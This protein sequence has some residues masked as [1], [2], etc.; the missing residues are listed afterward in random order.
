MIQTLLL[1]ILLTLGQQ[2]GA[3]LPAVSQTQARETPSPSRNSGKPPDPSA[4]DEPRVLQPGSPKPVPVPPFGR[5]GESKC[6]S[7]GNLY[8]AVGTNTA[9]RGPLLEISH[10]GS[11]S[12]AFAPPIPAK[13]D[14]G[15]EI[16]YRDFAVA[17]SGRVYEL[18]QNQNDQG[19]VV[20]EFDSDGS[21]HHA[22]KLDTPEHLLA[23][24]LAVF[25]EGTVLLKGAVRLKPSENESRGYVALFDASGK[26]LRELGGLPDLDLSVLKTA[27]QD[28]GVAIGQ[29]G[30]AY[31]LDPNFISVVSETGES[32]RRIPHQ[33]PDPALIARG[34]SLSNGLIAIRIL[35]VK[36]VEITQKYL[37]V[38]ADSGE[39]TGYY[40]LPDGTDAVGM[41][42]SRS[43]GFT[44]LTRR[45]TKLEL[46]NAP[47][48]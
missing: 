12:T 22:T 43:D 14:A 41:C 40:T 21:V 5:F 35:E 30:N 37:I 17:P 42:F 1:A 11:S 28:R 36:G 32:V 8:F 29:D 48:R 26:L 4:T 15:G 19:T 38:R 44:F 47:L 23:S 6:D 20:V 39:T 25:D 46:V 27:L 45:D 16:G 34:L 31:L 18:L 3:Q 9:R 7:S 24:S 10:D 2:A 13:L 33:K